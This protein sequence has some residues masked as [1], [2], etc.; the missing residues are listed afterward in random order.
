MPCSRLRCQLTESGAMI[1]E[2]IGVKHERHERCHGKGCSAIQTYNI[3]RADSVLLEALII[4]HDMVTT[5]S[6]HYRCFCLLHRAKTVSADDR[7]WLT[8]GLE[9][10]TY[11]LVL[12]TFLSW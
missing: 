1:T 2:Y 10:Y 11:L 9:V 3:K 8:S 12:L 4:S 5:N 7:A 6:N